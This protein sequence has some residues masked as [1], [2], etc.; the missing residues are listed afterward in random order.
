MKILRSRWVLRTAKLECGCGCHFEYD[1][2]DPV[3]VR[4]AGMFRVKCPE[5]EQEHY[6]ENL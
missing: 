4:E 6:V 5:C 2:S 1:S 3:F